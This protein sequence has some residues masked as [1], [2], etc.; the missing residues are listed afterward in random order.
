[1]NCHANVNVDLMEKNVIE[2][3]GRITINVDASVK[4]LMY[5]KKILFGILLH[6]IVKMG[7]I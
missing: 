2:I 4:K 6:V 1:M 3:N 7:N 5:L